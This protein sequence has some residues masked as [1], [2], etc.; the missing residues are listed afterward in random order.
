MIVH[1]TFFIKNETEKELIID[2]S[3][4]LVFGDDVVARDEIQNVYGIAVSIP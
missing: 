1:G 2:I 4:L 3:E